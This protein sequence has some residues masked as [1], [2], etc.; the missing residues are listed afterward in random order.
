MEALPPLPPSPPL[1]L[2]FLLLF[3]TLFVP[4]SSFCSWCFR[5]FLR[6]IFIK[7]TL[8]WLTGS[9]LTCSGSIAEPSGQHRAA[10]DLSPQRLPLQ[11]SPLPKSSYVHP[12]WVSKSTQASWIGNVTKLSASWYLFAG[13]QEFFY[14]TERSFYYILLLFIRHHHTFNIML[15]GCTYLWS[16]ITFY[17]ERILFINIEN[18]FRN[19]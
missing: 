16:H 12:V 8:T 11:S 3:L 9:A 5:L 6:N 7:V 10:P 13:Y 4:S 18:K 15:G 14:F 1:T 17:F 2:V 19:S